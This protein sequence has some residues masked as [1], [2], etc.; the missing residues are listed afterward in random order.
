MVSSAHRPRQVFPHLT[1]LSPDDDNSGDEAPI[2]KS[3]RP[4]QVDVAPPQGKAANAQS[5]R[6]NSAATRRSIPGQTNV[7]KQTQAK[8]LPASDAPAGTGFEK[9]NSRDDRG[10]GHGGAMILV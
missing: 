7:V 9:E 3:T 8:E 2:A 10:K 1:G 4:V 6:V 5:G